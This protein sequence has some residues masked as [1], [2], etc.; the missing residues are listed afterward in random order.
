MRLL[1]ALYS[2]PNNTAITEELIL[3]A[4]TNSGVSRIS[5]TAA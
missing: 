1:E 2:A 5:F 4:A 3:V